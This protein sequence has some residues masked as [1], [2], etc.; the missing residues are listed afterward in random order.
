MQSL[1]NKQFV[2]T[3]SLAQFP[4]V[5]TFVPSLLGINHAFCCSLKQWAVGVGSGDGGGKASRSRHTSYFQHCQAPS[6]STE[7]SSP[8]RPPLTTAFTLEIIRVSVWNVRG[9][10]CRDRPSAL[11]SLSPSRESLFSVSTAHSCFASC[12]PLCSV[13]G[14][15]FHWTLVTS[16]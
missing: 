11:Q 6:H 3:W 12:C 16:W 15:Y 13:A 9:V 2:R 14:R 4:K 8:G 1:A 5:V 10:T 7:A